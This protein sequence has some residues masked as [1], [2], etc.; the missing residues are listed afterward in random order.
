MAITDT[1][2]L[3]KFRDYFFQSDQYKNSFS[4]EGLRALYNYLW[5]LSEDMGEDIEMDYVAFSC[6]YSE[7]EDFKHFQ[8]DY[9]DI[10]NMGDLEQQTEVIKINDS[11]F[12]IRAF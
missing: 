12:I 4:Y 5:D 1:I 7:Y 11:S 8:E 10:G 6:E 2:T 9:K 3:S